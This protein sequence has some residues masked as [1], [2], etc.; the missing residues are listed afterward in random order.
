MTI[1]KFLQIFLGVANIMLPLYLCIYMI[2]NAKDIG[3]LVPKSYFL[4][5]RNCYGCKATIISDEDYYQNFPTIPNYGL[6]L[7]PQCRRDERLGIVNRFNFVSLYKINRFLLESKPVSIRGIQ[8]FTRI[9]ISVLSTILISFIIDFTLYIFFKNRF[10]IWDVFFGFLK[11]FYWT[12]FIYTS[13]IL[14]HKNKSTT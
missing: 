8:A 6:Q 3:S 10:P 7:C 2:A 5:G 11:V 9:D 13:T 1:I 4:N 14:T 12:Y